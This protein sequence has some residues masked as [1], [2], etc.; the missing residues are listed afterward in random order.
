MSFIDIEQIK[1]RLQDRLEVG[2]TEAEEV[3]NIVKARLELK[4]GFDIQELG[5]TLKDN[6][7]TTKKGTAWLTLLP[8][9]IKSIKNLETGE[10]LS[11]DEVN[12][13]ELRRSGKLITD[14]RPGFYEIGYTVWNKDLLK[15]LIEES[16]FDMSINRLNEV[17]S[18]I[19]SDI[20]SESIGDYSYQL[21]GVES[22]AIREAEKR[23]LARLNKW[24]GSIRAG[25]VR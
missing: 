11:S 25:V 10:K 17:D 24:T 19:D 12:R 4:L 14:L 13:L 21:G 7:K 20:K 3:I 23:A 16:I 15:Q 8:D 6:V 22:G 18:I 9:K 5:S 2:E 1:Q